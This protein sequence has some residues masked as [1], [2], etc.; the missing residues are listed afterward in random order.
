MINF[1]FQLY[2]ALIPFQDLFK[3]GEITLL[4][5]IAVFF[6]FFSTLCIFRSSIILKTSLIIGLACLCT[7]IILLLIEFFIHENVSFYSKYF[8]FVLNCLFFL[9]AWSFRKS[10]DFKST[11]NIILIVTTAV[12]LL[13][14]T[15]FVQVG[16]DG[17]VTTLGLNHN[18]SGLMVSTA[19]I[20]AISKIN[21][22]KTPLLYMNMVF[23][24]V[25][26]VCLLAIALNGTRFCFLLSTAYMIY[27]MIYCFRQRL[28]QWV[29]LFFIL[30]A[31]LIILMLITQPVLFTRL[32]RIHLE[33]TQDGRIILW[34]WVLS[35]LKESYLY[36]LGTEQYSVISNY[37][38]GSYMAPHNFFIEVFA[39]GGLLGIVSTFPH[40]HLA[41]YPSRHLVLSHEYKRLRVGLYLVIITT[42]LMHHVFF[43]K[44]Y[45]ILLLLLV[46]PRYQKMQ[47]Q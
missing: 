18:Y 41:K 12:A 11:I 39:Y 35:S 32:G 22:H 31:S 2:V 15:S 14:F 33:L 36:G 38:H 44:L 8:P 5:V 47:K 1:I 25:S 21:F 16:S 9:S 20:I 23:M 46:V 30:G 19:F 7:P 26:S 24:L 29:M 37:A 34:M 40:F 6:I 27:I 43:N 3:L 17:R 13:H 45:W 28:F 4:R 42:L 10:I